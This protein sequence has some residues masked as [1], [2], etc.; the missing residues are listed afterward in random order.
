[1]LSD[2]V[3][4][5]F[6]IQY[7]LDDLP[8]SPYLLLP[9]LGSSLLGIFIMILACVTCARSD[10]EVKKMK[11]LGGNIGQSGIPNN[12]G[13]GPSLRGSNRNK[14]PA[15]DDDSSV[16][17]TEE[18]NSELKQEGLGIFGSERKGSTFNRQRFLKAAKASEKKKKRK[19]AAKKESSIFK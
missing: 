14:D 10:A 18:N 17:F 8:I 9:F 12:V 3:I 13:N 4:S 16:N 19:L 5:V 11:L 1:M 6:G 15:E 2:H 7:D